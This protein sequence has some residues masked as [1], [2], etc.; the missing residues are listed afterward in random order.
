MNDAGHASRH[1]PGHE[2]DDRIA[3]YALGVLDSD[4]CR[5][6]E[7]HLAG[8]PGCRAELIRYEAT[9]GE[10]GF[11][12]TPVPPRPELRATLLS[13]SR[14]SA[15]PS[16]PTS[17]HRRRVPAAWLGVAAAIALISIAILGVL[18]VRTVGERDD[19]AHAEQ[20]IAEYL[21]DGGTL[22][23][24]LP[25][26]GAPASV[27]PGHGTLAVAP[28]QSQAMLIV[29]GLTPSG[30]G[31]RYMA[32]AERDGTRVRLGELPVNAEGVGWLVLAA[33]EPMSSYE[34]VGITRFSPDAP[35]G[36]PYLVAPIQQAG[37]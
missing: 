34:T 11:G 18:L 9:V 29:H 20:E 23:P 10:L 37:A 32:W 12:A 14:A 13:E 6:L 3:A 1:T 35:D 22:S 27:A 25:D 15:P 16:I 4:E 5:A 24:L 33:P 7:A 2:P 36:E 8:C 17:L 26:T 28:D 31:Q 21:S 30:D 19:A